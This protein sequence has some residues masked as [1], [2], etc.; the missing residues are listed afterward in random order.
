MLAGDDKGGM[1][2]GAAIMAAKIYPVAK[3]Y[4]IKQGRTP[5]QVDALPV[6]QVAL[7][8]ALSQHDT[9]FDNIFKWHNLPFWEADPGV[10]KATKQLKESKSKIMETGGIPIAELL[11]PAVSKVLITRA[12]VDRRIAAL[13][14]IEAIRLFAAANDGKLPASLNDIRE[15]PIPIDPFTG[16]SFEYRVEKGKAILLGRWPEGQPATDFNTIRYELTLAPAG[17]EKD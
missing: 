8:Y 7:M 2:F 1:R 5:D 10:N 15:V 9:H 13:R 14:C 17:K 3:K 16:K 6:T 4:L 11:I 12:R